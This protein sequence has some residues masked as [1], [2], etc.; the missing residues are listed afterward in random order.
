[1]SL[2]SLSSKSVS[3]N[4]STQQ[5]PFNFKNFFPQPIVIKPKSQVCLTTFY[6]FRTEGIYNIN[7]NNNLIGFCFGDRQNNN[8]MYASLTKGN[9]EGDELATEI[10]RAMNASNVQQ[11]YLWTATFTEGS[12]VAIP[13]TFDEFTLT[14][15]NVPTPTEKGGVW[16]KFSS[17]NQNGTLDNQ[18]L[19]DEFS[20]IINLSDDPLPVKL[21]NGL[22]LHEG[23]VRYENIGLSHNHASLDAPLELSPLN[24]GI[25]QS[26]MAVDSANLSDAT[27]FQSKFG[28]I[29]VQTIEK[30][31]LISTLN[32]KQGNIAGG[33]FASNDRG[34]DQIIRR[35]FD[36]NFLNTIC[37]SSTDRL[38]FNIYRVSGNRSWVIT[39]QK[40]VDNGATYTDI[41]DG[42][43]NNADGRPNVYSDTIG[44]VSY[45]SVLYS[46]IGV[47]DGGGGRDTIN[48]VNNKPTKTIESASNRKAPFIPYIEVLERAEHTTGLDLED[49][50]F[51]LSIVPAQGNPSLI[52][53]N[54]FTMTWQ[55]DTSGNG[56]D[57]GMF[58]S[59][60]PTTPSAQINSTQMADWVV[61]NLAV[62]GGVFGYDVFPNNTVDINSAVK[63]ADLK[64]DPTEG[65]NGSWELS[66]IDGATGITMTAVAFDQEGGKP[67]IIT[68]DAEFLFQGI[69]NPN[70]VPITSSDGSMVS[71]NSTSGRS[72]SEPEEG[73]LLLNTIDVALGADL[74]QQS[75]II[76][77]RAN[78]QTLAQFDGNPVRSNGIKNQAG[79][80]YTLKPLQR[81]GTAFKVLGFSE[82]ILVNDTTTF[83]F[84]SNNKPFIQ[85]D[86]TSLHISIPE[87][88]GIIS[89][90]GEA[91]NV[92]K[93][94]KVIPKNE[95]TESSTSEAMTF[96]APFEEWIDINNAEPLVLNEMTLQVRKPD[97]TMATNLKPITRATIKIQEDPEVKK[98]EAQRQMIEAMA[99]TKAQSQNTGNLQLMDASSW[100][101]S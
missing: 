88:S 83:D 66:N 95:F 48:P 55:P 54:Q 62:D 61:G 45:S 11:N 101:G 41:T 89:Y 67:D 23:F 36:E 85:M 98:L 58:E 79:T 28:D 59:T 94:I 91:E 14:Y 92:S 53:D 4:D 19:E 99:S 40:S 74:A 22:L 57:Y 84:I 82:M 13:Q 51:T 31:I 6:H 18:D 33:L 24:M 71:E 73:A 68:E 75:F 1:M 69:F 26:A 64:Y 42:Q 65:A 7:S 81:F 12:A 87:L 77:G 34:K 96:T 63:I 16:S 38:S 17:R 93:T 46:T 47:P 39:C 56:F 35:E 21:R 5:A 97:G 76:L 27:S 60:A 32:Q 80:G 20:S 15:E 90:E 2:I 100:V 8:V 52:A 29:L 49:E 70:N 9:Y 43:G 10:A 72:H 50:E 25:V 30:R 3:R 37:D 86:E 78:Q 44:G